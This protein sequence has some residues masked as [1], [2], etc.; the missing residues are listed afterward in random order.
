M[1]SFQIE[2]K[3]LNES[4][5]LKLKVNCLIVFREMLNVLSMKGIRLGD[6]CIW[7]I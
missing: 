3:L 7:Y 5:L 2:S 4:K 1:F 6:T